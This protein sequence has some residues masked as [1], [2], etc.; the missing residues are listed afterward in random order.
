MFTWLEIAPLSRTLRTVKGG[1]P[2]NTSVLPVSFRVNQTWVPSGVAAMLG[3]NGL[4]CLTRA[5]MLCVAT[6][7]TSVVG[8]EGRTNITVL[9]IRREDLHA[10]A[11]GGDDAGLFHEG[12]AV[13][14]IDIVLAADRDPD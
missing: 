2:S 8:V 12:L 4:A 6:E 3:Q 14:D 7:T 10:G 5:T 9:A 1:F 11:C 13:E